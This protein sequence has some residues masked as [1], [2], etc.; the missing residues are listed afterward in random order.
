M[1]LILILSLLIVA[2]AVVFAVQNAAPVSVAFFSW[3]FESSLALLLL[4]AFC[5]GV[6]ASLLAS[7]PSWLR[8]RKRLKEKDRA[9]KDLQDNL[10]EYKN[11]INPTET[12]N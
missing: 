6:A 2:A 11:L 1:Q 10:V 3:N 8:A 9:I 5:L 4:A 7:L 12:V